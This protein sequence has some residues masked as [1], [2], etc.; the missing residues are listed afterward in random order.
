[1]NLHK[2]TAMMAVFL[3]VKITSA[4]SVDLV[5]HVDVVASLVVIEAVVVAVVDHAVD[6]FLHSA[7]VDG[8][9]SGCS[10]ASTSMSLL[11]RTK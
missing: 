11:D 8:M 6:D 3:F 5:D 10:F 9:G 4:D 2:K 1:M 7:A